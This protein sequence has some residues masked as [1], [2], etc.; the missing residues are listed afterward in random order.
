[1]IL[2]IPDLAGYDKPVV[3]T[4][5]GEAVRAVLS[6]AKRSEAAL[7]KEACYSRMT[8]N[9]YLRG[10]R[11]PDAVT[12][13]RLNRCTEELVSGQGV[14]GNVNVRA[15]L[16][17]EAMMDGLL[18]DGAFGPAGPLTLAEII[19]GAMTTLEALGAGVL[20][21]DWGQRLI[22]ANK[23]DISGERISRLLVDLNRLHGRLLLDAIGGRVPAAKGFNS[24]RGIL[25]KHALSGLLQDDTG[26]ADVLEELT[27]EIR[28]ALITVVG[29]DV[30]AVERF[31]AERKLLR[32]ALTFA[33]QILATQQILGAHR[34]GTSAEA[35]ALAVADVTLGVNEPKP[36][37][38]RGKKGNK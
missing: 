6:R 30:T 16:D 22:E 9:R 1:M 38:K 28:K 10:E 14:P 11:D 7:A 19:D 31:D 24:L 29:P 8:V 3:V 25:A 2:T 37:R 21:D 36:E 26:P 15:Y 35:Y 5:W 34:P 4:G 32:I 18:G 23:S 12:V 20:R 13:L 33:Q 17:A 27:L